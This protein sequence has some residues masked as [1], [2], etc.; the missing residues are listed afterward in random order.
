M[1][2]RIIPVRDM[3]PRD[4]RAWRDLAARSIEPNPLY[5]PDCVIPAARHQT[6]GA[7]IG[8]VVAESDEGF[9]ACMPVRPLREWWGIPFPIVANWIR[10]STYVGTPLLDDVD[11]QRAMVTIFRTLADGRRTLGYRLLGIDSLRHG[12]P[13]STYVFAAAR[14]LGLSTHVREDFE[15]GFLIRRPEPSYLEGHSRQFL[16]QIRR[17]QRR[18]A[19]ALGGDWRVVDRSQDPAA[20]RD[21]VVL[22]AAGYKAQTMALAR[23]PGEPEYFIDMCD[24][25]AVEKRLIVL[26]LEGGG[27]TLAMQMWLRGGSGLVLIKLAHDERYAR[28]SPGIHLEVESFDFFHHQTDADWIDSCA[29][30]NNESQLHIFPDRTR[31]LTVLFSLGSRVDAMVVKHRQGLRRVHR[32]AT[33]FRSQIRQPASQPSEHQ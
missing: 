11:A 32:L 15:R 24:R 1:R 17:K 10:R 26:S 21:F 16:S 29:G 4:E 14:E 23:T 9:H 20:I 8:L 19:E 31:I 18:L 12:S 6:F 7:E 28:F 33:Q 30:A 22:E 27:Q 5:E 3:A 2:G 25:F 13:V